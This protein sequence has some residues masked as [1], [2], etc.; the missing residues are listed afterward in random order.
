M[1]DPYFQK[2]ID[3]FMK[4]NW[5]AFDENANK[6]QQFQ[7]FQNY[8]NEVEQYIQTVH[9]SSYRPSRKKFLTLVG[10]ALDN[11]LLHG[12]IL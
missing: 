5:A 8:K 2:M 9:L 4:N 6:E 11:F 12:E 3:L 10:R 1:I 7:V